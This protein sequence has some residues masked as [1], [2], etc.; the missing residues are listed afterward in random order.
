MMV[1]GGAFTLGTSMV[2]S[3]GYYATVF[4]VAGGDRI[5]GD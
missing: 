2:G 5:L 3:L 4:Y 1:M